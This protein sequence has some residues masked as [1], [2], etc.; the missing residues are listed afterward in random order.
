MV[1]LILAL[2][3]SAFAST[4]TSAASLITRY[5]GTN[6]IATAVAISR[7]T[8]APGVR[9]VYLA[10][11]SDLAY[12]LPAAAAAGARGGPVLLTVP[13]CAAHERSPTS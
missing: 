11:Q 8:F 2:A 5:A 12:S 1:P 7:A 9:V 4:P 3:V 6:R 13:Q 10:E